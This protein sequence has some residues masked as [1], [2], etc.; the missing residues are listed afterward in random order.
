M[1]TD[2]VVTQYISIGGCILPNTFYHDTYDGSN[3]GRVL[4]S[5]VVS[6][7]I[8]CPYGTKDCECATELATYIKVKYSTYNNFIHVYPEYQ[9]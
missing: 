2:N 7:C 9:I 6:S 1:T 5:N 4:C 8:E 3:N